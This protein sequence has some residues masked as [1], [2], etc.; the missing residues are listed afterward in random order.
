MDDVL[1]RITEVA[2]DRGGRS[3]LY[4]WMWRNRVS[5]AALLDENRPR[6]QALADGFAEMGMA[7][8]EG[9]L[10]AE[11]VRNTWW[12]VRRDQANR[13]RPSPAPPVVAAAT[14]VPAPGVDPLAALRKQ[15]DERSG[16]IG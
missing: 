1:A 12:R 7:G 3:R 9:V 10:K 16:K 4:R 13:R 6:W 8:P 11:S 5:F 14:P 15:M 2:R